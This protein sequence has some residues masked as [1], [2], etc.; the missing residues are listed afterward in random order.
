MKSWGGSRRIWERVNCDQNILSEKNFK[1]KYKIKK[2]KKE[3]V[4]ASQ[5]CPESPAKHVND[6]PT[7]LWRFMKD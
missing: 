3:Y 7:V 5:F 1:E 6:I 2:Q 4:F